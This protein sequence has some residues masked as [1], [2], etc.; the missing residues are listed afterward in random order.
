MWSQD[1]LV[2]TTDRCS[3]A[4]ISTIAL[5]ANSVFSLN[6]AA[7]YSSYCRVTGASEARK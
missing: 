4:E 1:D 7:Q 3:A 2:F 6:A 5:I